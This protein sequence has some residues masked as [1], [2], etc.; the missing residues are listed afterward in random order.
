MP[1][2]VQISRRKHHTPEAYVWQLGHYGLH[3]RFRWFLYCQEIGPRESH[4]HLHFLALF[5]TGNSRAYE[6]AIRNEFYAW[7]HDDGEENGTPIPCRNKGGFTITVKIG[8]NGSE[9]TVERMQ[10]YLLKYAG[11]A[12]IVNGAGEGMSERS[13][14]LNHRNWM[15]RAAK[16]P[17]LPLGRAN[18]FDFVWRFMTVNL[19]MLAPLMSFRQ[20]LRMALIAP[21]ES[22]SVPTQDL[23]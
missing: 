22:R 12:S 23:V 8:L 13:H 2:H 1:V 5:R 17:G 10:G 20:C 11:A 18:L 3:H 16:R 21:A 7:L 14:F 19:K 9:H 6:Q 15:M 4:R